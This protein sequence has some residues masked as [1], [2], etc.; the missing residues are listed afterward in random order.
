MLDFQC[1]CGKT[2]KYDSGYY[3]HKK[4]CSFASGNAFDD[5]HHDNEVMTVTSPDNID[6]MMELIKQNQEFKELIVEQNKQIM[7]LAQN[8][9]LQII[10]LTIIKNS[11]YRYF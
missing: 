5:N 6:T 1:I 7:E 10:L 8:Q 2:Y 3:R 11:I 9:P 4:I